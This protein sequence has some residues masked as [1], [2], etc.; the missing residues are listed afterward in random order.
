MRGRR[1]VE[2]EAREVHW[3]TVA[4]VTTVAEVEAEESVACLQACHEDCHI[5]LCTRVGLYVGILSA[6]ELA[7]ALACD[8]LALIYD[9]ATAVVA[10]RQVT[11]LK[12]FGSTILCCTP[13]YALHIAETLYAGGYTK[14]DISL[15]AGVFGAEPW[16]LPRLP[17][18]FLFLTSGQSLLICPVL[19][20]L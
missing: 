16:L 18:S 8:V 4:E 15:K 11:I 10:Q 17:V 12:D 3:R 14:E 1:C 9:F 6:K 7:E 20:Q 5:G 19:L 2:H 13:S